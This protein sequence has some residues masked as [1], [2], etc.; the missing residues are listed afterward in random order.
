MGSKKFPGIVVSHYNRMIYCNAYLISFKI[1]PLRVY[2]QTHTHTHTHTRYIDRVNVG[3]S[4]GRLLLDLRSSTVAFHLMSFIVAKRVPL[5]L[6]FR[7]GNSQRSLG[8]RSGEYGGWMM[9]GK[10]FWARNC[11]T[12]V[13]CGSVRYRDAETIALATCHAA[14]S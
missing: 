8:A 1:G 6:I 11:C 14:S 5:R 13:I 12:T 4:G 3:S 10:F 7:V 2:T 9:T